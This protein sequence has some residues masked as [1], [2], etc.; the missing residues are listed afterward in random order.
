LSAARVRVSDAR[1]EAA[2]ASKAAEP[3]RAERTRRRRSRAAVI[4]AGCAAVAVIAVIAVVILAISHG[5]AV[6]ERNRDADILADTRAAVVT[7]LTIDPA[8]PDEFVDGAVA[9]TSG[10]QRERLETSRAQL[11]EVIG[12]MAVPSTGQVLS[13]GIVGDVSENTADVLVVAEGTN[14]TVLGADPSQS[15][16]ALLITMK[17]SGE[18]WTIDRTQLQ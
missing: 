12:A 9:V 17:D 14:P 6:Q 18:R 13:A 10:A 7:M 15:R 1:A 3:A 16:V 5:K 4:S 8:A 11:V 2:R